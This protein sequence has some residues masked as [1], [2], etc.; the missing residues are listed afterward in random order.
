MNL[1]IHSAIHFL[2]LRGVFNEQIMSQIKETYGDGLIH[3]QGVQRWTHDFAAVRTELDALPRSGRPRDPENPDRIRA[4]FESEF[5]ISQKRLS[6]RL[7]LHQNIV[8]RILTEEL[9]LCKANFK[10]FCIP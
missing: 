3:L 4:L 6:K 8:H 5:H 2:W 9:G 10:G 1:K 7:N